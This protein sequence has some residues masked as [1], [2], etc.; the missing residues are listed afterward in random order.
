[1]ANSLETSPLV[2]TQNR[3]KDHHVNFRKGESIWQDLERRRESNPP[4]TGRSTAVTLLFGQLVALICSSQNAVSFALEFGMGK[5]FP[6]FLM[7]HAY[8]L[9]SFHLLQNKH[10]SGDT[11]HTLP[12]TSIRLRTPWWYYLCLSIFDVGPNYL[13][14]LAL[15]YTSLMSATL[16]GSITVPST[17]FF[18]RFLLAKQYNRFHLVGVIF[19]LTGG[20]LTV[21]ADIDRSD[22]SM[23]PT[24]H[25]HSYFGDLLGLGAALLYGLGDACGE[26]WTKHVDRKEYLGMIGLFGSLFTLILFLVFEWEPVCDL[27]S[28]RSTFLPAF[29]LIVVYV[30]LLVAYYISATLFLISSDATLLNL[31]L[32]SSNLW[33]ILFSVVF[34]R[35]LPSPLFFLALALVISGVFVF[36]LLGNKAQDSE[37]ERTTTS[38]PKQRSTEYDTIETI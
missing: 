14:L 15:K 12:F 23:H 35:E 28:D 22:G 25:P 7:F 31:S 17:M 36:E 9:L 3:S 32:Q 11:L 8:V 4:Q 26:F 27:M 29:G 13:T 16:L 5:V 19:C 30:P 2:Q 20:I 10:T 6:F 34:F 24:S 1:M 37:A 38:P 21:R 18:C 33:A